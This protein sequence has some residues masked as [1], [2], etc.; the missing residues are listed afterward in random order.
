[1]RLQTLTVDRT[2]CS[3]LAAVCNYCPHC[4][5]PMVAPTASEFVA[6][7]GIRHRW[8]CDSCGQETRT[9]IEF[10]RI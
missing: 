10:R 2:A 5:E 4:A 7:H 9:T 1:M 8:I 6:G 3:Y